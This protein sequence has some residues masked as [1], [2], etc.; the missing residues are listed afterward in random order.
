MRWTVPQAKAEAEEQNPRNTSEHHRLQ[1][2][3]RNVLSNILDA[4]KIDEILRC[5]DIPYS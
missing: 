3:G 5:Y 2:E 1:V 4:P